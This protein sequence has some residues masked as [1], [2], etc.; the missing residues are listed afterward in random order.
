MFDGGRGLFDD[1]FNFNFSAFRSRPMSRQISKPITP[2]GELAQTDQAFD[3]RLQAATLACHR[4]LAQQ[5]G[6]DDGVDPLSGIQSQLARAADGPK[7]A[8]DGA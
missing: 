7:G 8:P 3:E 5:A 1:V 6:V 2:H 4:R